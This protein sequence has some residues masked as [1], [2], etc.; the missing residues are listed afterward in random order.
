M[1]PDRRL[2]PSIPA[3]VFFI[4]WIVASVV[5]P[6][7]MLNADGD[8]LRH[9]GHGNWML[10]HGRLITED[11]F[12]F[13]RGGQPFTAF[14]YG[15]QIVLALVHNAAGLAGVAI[16][17][18]CLCSLPQDIQVASRDPTLDGLAPTLPTDL[19]PYF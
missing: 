7:R 3:I 16:F 2:H 10:E 6:D 12:S 1:T 13:T 11:P 19:K 5:F 18:A 15:S 4:W 9:I 8:M 14:E 17:N